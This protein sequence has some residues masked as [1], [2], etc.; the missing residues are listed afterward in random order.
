LQI[1]CVDFMRTLSLLV[2]LL[3]QVTFLF[4]AASTTGNIDSLILRGQY[5]GKNLIVMNPMNNNVFA[6]KFVLL[7]GNQIQPEIRSNAFEVNF[8]AS[9]LQ[10]GDDV[11]VRVMYDPSVGKPQIFNPEVLKP[12]NDFRFITAECDKKNLIIHWTVACNNLSESFELEH[13]RWEK[14]MTIQLINPNEVK[15]FPNFGASFI[16]H[17]GRNLFRVKYIDSDGNIFYSTDIKY[18]SKSK[19]VLLITD[20]V[21]STIDFSEE[22]LYQLFDENGAFLLDGWGNSIDIELMNKGKYFLN[23]DNKTVVVTKK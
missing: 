18:T 1:N 8:S 6:V 14:W 3:F 2:F 12:M 5:S 10:L 11:T 20:K 23:F 7:N 15:T 9:G 13:Y 19:E 16:P 17:S 4:S 21:K 22:T